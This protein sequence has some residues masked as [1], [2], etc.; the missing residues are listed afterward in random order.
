MK[1]KKTLGYLQLS[2]G[3]IFAGSSVVVGKIL[4]PYPV[5]FA[6][7]LSLIIAVIF[8]YPIAIIVEGRIKIKEVKKSEWKYII[9]QSLMGI[10]FFRIFMML[11]L[12]YTSAMKAGIVLSATPAVLAILA[13][14]FLKE[15]ITKIMVIGISLCVVGILLI[16]ISRIEIKS[17]NVNE[18]IGMF[19]I[20]ISVISE[21]MFTIFRKKQ[22]SG[23]KPLI[24]TF[25]V[26]LIA[27]VLLL[28]LGIN[29][30]VSMDKSVLGIDIILPIVYY[31]VFA[32]ALAYVCWFS[33]LVKVNANEAAAFT[34]LMPIA[35]VLLS[36]I[37]LGEKIRLVYIFGIVCILLGINLITKK[38]TI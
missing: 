25:L 22:G 20:L 37:V 34:G 14:L 38:K 17:F 31:G 33:G 10:V 26:M 16:N 4:Q 19:F 21:A 9:L 11:G 15:N 30:F 27:F 3:M 2:M 29:D 13:R 24:S 5:F 7:D 35:S 32:S 36:V 28:P 12:K 8:I 18:L 23:E 1:N 6:V